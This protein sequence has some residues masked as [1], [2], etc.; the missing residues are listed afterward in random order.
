LTIGRSSFVRPS[1]KGKQMTTR[2]SA[3]VLSVVLMALAS[4]GAGAVEQL[5]GK[6]LNGKTLNGKTLNGRTA[7][8]GKHPAPGA[9]VLPGG[10]VVVLK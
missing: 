3:A 2:K 1:V 9:V 5:N 6:T 4:S 7:S 10:A 8:R